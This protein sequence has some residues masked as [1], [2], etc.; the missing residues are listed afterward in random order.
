MNVIHRNRASTRRHPGGSARRVRLLAAATVLAAVV[1]T[2]LVAVPALAFTDVPVT[3]TYYTAITS[4]SDRKVVSGFDPSTF[5]PERIVKRMQFAKMIVLDLDFLVTTSDRCTFKDVDA[6]TDP[7][8]PLYPDHYI[9]VATAQ[10]LIMG[11]PEDNT[12]RPQKSVTRRQVITMVVRAAGP[13]LVHPPAN[14]TGENG[15]DYSDPTHGENIRIAEFNGLLDGLAGLS[16]SWD[17]GAPATRGECAQVL[18]NLSLLLAPEGV[19]VNADGSGDYPTI[20]DAVANIDTGETIFLGP[21]VF[22]LDQTLSVD[23]SFNLVGSG[24]DQTTV[25]CNDIVADVGPVSFGASD[26]TFQSTATSIATEPVIAT[27][28]T[29]DLERCRFTGGNRV[30]G[31]DGVG[32]GGSGLWLLG[33]TTG[34]VVDCVGSNNELNGI[35]VDNESVV[36]LQ[37]NLCQANA[38][39]GIVYHDTSGGTASGNRCINN[40]VDGIGANNDSD[41]LL[42]NNY[43]AGNA[44]AG[45]FFND[46][47][48]ATARNN[49]C[50]NNKWGIYVYVD[51]DPT[52][53]NNNLHGN[54]VSPQLYDERVL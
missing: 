46:Y 6:S 25:R 10:G 4:L 13:A 7:T 1:I 3:H 9:A 42:E 28:S 37:N 19:T 24:M 35:N 38:Q 12:F 33:S 23:F 22:T 45:I 54:T 20:E 52:L 26:L 32:N 30:V 49:E 5:G 14:W 29:I 31:S 51:A 34:S 16:S 11:Y 36:A 39:D 2:L 27:D 21:G 50:T 15:L 18:Y 43:C 44:E 8:D 40:G 41:P 17:S 48:T 47:T 53:S